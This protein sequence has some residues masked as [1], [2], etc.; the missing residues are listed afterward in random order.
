MVMNNTFVVASDLLYT[1]FIV[2]LSVQGDTEGMFIPYGK[3]KIL[4][5]TE[6]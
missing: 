5:L 1:C 6:E 2:T 4:N 3:G